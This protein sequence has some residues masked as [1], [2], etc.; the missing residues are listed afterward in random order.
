MKRLFVCMTMVTVLAVNAVPGFSMG[1]RVE[2]QF[3]RIDT[4]KEVRNESTEQSSH[5]SKNCCKSY[6]DLNRETYY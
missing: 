6:N 5:D 1:K 3:D 2:K 4:S